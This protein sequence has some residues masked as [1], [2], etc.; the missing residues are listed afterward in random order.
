MATA[1]DVIGGSAP[2]SVDVGDCL[3]WL[4]T[5]PGGCV[6][7]CAS[8][9]P[10]YGLRDYGP[11]GQIGLEPTM[12]EYVARLVE[13]FR[14]VRRVLR[15]DGT[16]WL[17]LGDSYNADGRKGRA[18]MGEGKNSGYS[19]W[20]NKNPAG[21]KPKDLLMVPARVAIALCD[22]GWFL[23]SEISLTKLSPMP[24]SCRDRPSRAT[25]KLY[26]LA[27]RP[28]YYYD[29]E[30]ER[31]P[32]AAASL[33]RLAPGAAPR[34]DKAAAGREG[35]ASNTMSNARGVSPAGRNLWDYWADATEDVPPAAWDWVTE[36]QRHAHYAAFPSW[37]PRRC[38]RLGASLKGCCP[39]CGAPWRRQ[40]ERTKVTRS[41]PNDY[42]KRTGGAG[43]GNSCKNTVAGVSAVTTGWA[44]SCACPPR[45][46]AP[47]VVL[48]PFTGS[49]TTGA[50]ARDLGMRFLGVDINPEYAEMARRRIGSANPLM[51]AC[52]S[53]AAPAAGGAG[54]FDAG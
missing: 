21:T 10:Y 23:R 36:P 19:A 20:A 32:P 22:D 13:V 34:K 47:C 37:L 4:R 18:H 51:D 43:T 42:T 46:P 27:K 17:N 29:Q 9:P 53:A 31:V 25:E 15:E 1:A 44:P 33:A 54:L 2:W 39:A 16:L 14:E 38:L 40:V 7:T 30:A 3:A 26:L 8:S 5:L 35:L 6:Q 28:A 11:E 24:E 50:V 12:G 48:D 52:D 45:E 49:G 41:R